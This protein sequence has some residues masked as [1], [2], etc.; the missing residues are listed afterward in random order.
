MRYSKKSQYTEID[1]R[2]IYVI[3]SPLSD[4]CFIGH[5]RK[6]LLMSVYRHHK[7]CERNA[8]RSLCE[9]LSNQELHPCLFIIET[10][11]CTK[12]EAYK[13]VV[14]WVKIFIDAGYHVL[15]SGET[16]SSGG[17]LLD[18]NI[19]RYEDRKATD[20]AKILQCNNC[21]VQTYNRK[22]CMHFNEYSC[23]SK[24]NYSTPE[25]R[26]RDKEI[27]IRVSTEEYDLIQKNAKA[28][29]KTTVAYLRELGL[30]MCI[31]PMDLDIIREHTS[32]ITSYRN[33]INQLIFTIRKTGNY[34]PLDIEYILEK[35]RALL[36]L[37]N[38][39]LEQYISQ[40]E[41][42]KKDIPKIVR[43]IVNKNLSKQSITSKSLKNK[44]D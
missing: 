18:E 10:V 34:V 8:T 39:F 23:S 21:I 16:I 9:G 5:C 43:K 3:K 6:D 24:N 2:T 27:R 11:N 30:N 29:D 32:V 4:D 12:V 17:D 14:V 13:H 41:Q 22:K 42:T 15:N 35:T 40:V 25:K 31:V 44:S 19:K 1:D 33:A 38:K 20:V 37:E 28:C 7:Y 36:N 26:L